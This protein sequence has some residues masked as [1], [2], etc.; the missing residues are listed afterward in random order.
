MT[1]WVNPVVFQSNDLSSA[2]WANSTS[3]SGAVVVT[4]N[5]GDPPDPAMP[6]TA[7][8]LSFTR[9]AVADE[10]CRYHQFTATAVNHIGAIKVKAFAAA[11]VGKSI[12]LR[13][14]DG[15]AALASIPVTLTAAYQRVS[16]AGVLT[17]SPSANM[18]IGFN[19][20]A[21]TQIGTVN[22]LVC[23]ADVLSAAPQT[24]APAVD[25]AATISYL[26]PYA[27][28][29][30]WKA[31]PIGVVLG[32][33]TIGPA[34]NQYPFI[35]D[36][37]NYGTN[38]Y[39]GVAS[40]PPMTVHTVV[41]DE[42]VTR[43]V[44]VPHWPAGVTTGTAGD[45]QLCIYDQP[46]GLF[47]SFWLAGP[48]S[49]GATWTAGS[50][51][52]EPYDGWGFGI[53]SRPG[54]VRGGGS[55][56]IAG[57]LR[58]WEFGRSV[59]NHAIAFEIDQTGIHTGPVPPITMEDYGM[60]ANPNATGS[61]TYG[62]RMM[63]PPTFNVNSLANEPCRVIARTL[64]LY[65]GICVDTTGSTFGLS[66]E[67]GGP[68]QGANNYA[69]LAM[70]RD[71]LRNV[72]SVTGWQDGNGIEFTPPTWDQMNLLSMRGPW[73]DYSTSNPVQ[74]GA[75]NAVSNLY[76]FP[77][78]VAVGIVN[79]AVYYPRGSPAN[80]PWTGWR[81]QQSFFWSPVAG[82]QY[83]LTA[84]GVGG[85]LVSTA[86]KIFGSTPYISPNLFPGDTAT[87]VWP[88]GWDS[89]QLYVGKAAGG[90]ASIRLEMV[91]V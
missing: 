63:L 89:M 88:A 7:T 65:G 45:R 58:T 38:F 91:A 31:K 40:D 39:V 36:S 3:G 74:A 85:A 75:W 48:A 22:A 8:K 44:I 68:W 87:F 46:S 28:T 66:A 61:I 20:G 29:S 71:E 70:I 33:A 27:V 10:A 42:Q 4:A 67:V 79:K 12:T 90:P 78:T 83:K 49:G 23:V 52:V 51:I 6:G 59:L 47:Y 24:V 56:N 64:M 37:P 69:D 32:A 25:P 9:T 11:D 41:D 86:I 54:G 18:S 15:V 76:E 57:L 13:F 19:G 34:A 77:N 55:S 72:V 16:T 81:G 26:N 17:N 30:P 1:E 53:P 73:S 80:E 43:D 14:Y 84:Y 50:F 62:M 5:A 21:D 2:S 60:Y 82:T 35:I